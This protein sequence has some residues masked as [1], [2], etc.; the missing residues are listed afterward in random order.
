[1]A[2]K[3][4]VGKN[5][6]KLF[7]VYVCVRGTTGKNLQF[8][9]RGLKSLRA[10]ENEEFE[11][12]RRLCDKRESRSFTWDEWHKEFVGRMKVQFMN[13]TV[14]EYIGQIEKWV[15]PQWTGRDLQGITPGD[16]HELVFTSVRE[17]SAN[18]RRNI[19]KKIKR[20]FAMAVEE[21]ILDRN[22]AIPVKVK[23]PEA[24]QGVLNA[25]EVN[26]LLQEGKNLN[27]R[28]YYVWAMALFTGM[29]SGELY[30][31]RWT[32]IDFASRRI[33]VTKS[34]NSKNGYGPTK[35]SHNRVVPIS[36]KLESLLKELKIQRG[37]D[38]FVLPHLD[39]W[40]RGEQAMVLREFCT[41]IGI[42][43]VKF[44][45]LRAT[46]ITQMLLKGV[47]LAQVMSIV[48]HAELKT[49]NEY[50][51]IVGADLDGATE[52]LSFSL[53]TNELAK[54]IDISIKT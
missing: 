25:S 34:W 49:T 5:G 44:H 3:S 31:L 20:I 41:Q 21:G 39:E 19:H 8:R 7:E 16:V 46:F 17:V 27:H 2:I 37:S 40:A 6:E 22:P 43:S 9:K 35:S 45:D 38:E 28:F 26:V 53:P 47:S 24:K 33:S 4:Y 51:R 18:T 13:S 1:M 11:A 36:A 54:V 23:V 52:K 14:M 30:A 42:T 12:K 10:A 29:R 15:T 48:G 50:L 32:D